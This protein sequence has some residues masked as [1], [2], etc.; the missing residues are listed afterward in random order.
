MANKKVKSE[1]IK[2]KLA[3]HGGA[4][5][6]NSQGVCITGNK[7]HEVRQTPMILKGIKGGALV[8]VVTKSKTPPNNP[9][10]GGSGN[11]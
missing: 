5:F 11:E 9:P 7:V 6:D 4:Y 8:K 10:E 2:V 1:K 3:V